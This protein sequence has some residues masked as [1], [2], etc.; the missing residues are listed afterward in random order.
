LKK[1]AYGELTLVFPDGYIEKTAITWNAKK[2]RN[3]AA[4]ALAEILECFKD[5]NPRPKVIDYSGDE[6]NRIK[7][8]LD[9]IFTAHLRKTMLNAIWS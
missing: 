6:E 5:L 8:V 4:N 1:Q 9:E 7:V 3:G 2:G